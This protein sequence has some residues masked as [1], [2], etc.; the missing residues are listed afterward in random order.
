MQYR[1]TVVNNLHALHLYQFGDVSTLSLFSTLYLYIHWVHPNFLFYWAHRC[2][3]SHHS[4]I[5]FPQTKA[6]STAV[7]WSLNLTFLVKRVPH[8]QHVVDTNPQISC[9]YNV[10]MGLYKEGKIDKRTLNFPLIEPQWASVTWDEIC[11]SRWNFPRPNTDT[12]TTDNSVAFHTQSAH[13][14]SRQLLKIL[15]L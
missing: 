14:R 12:V 9:M 3:S 1:Q 6:D 8:V 15:H 11:S 13:N 7:C 10:H 5:I 4:P 2:A